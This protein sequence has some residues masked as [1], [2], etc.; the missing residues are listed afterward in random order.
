VKLTVKNWTE[1][2]HYK[3]RCPPW[4]KLHRKILDDRSFQRLPDASR[5]LAPCIWLL[6]SEST[7]GIFDGSVEEVAFRVRQ[8]EQWVEKAIKP[9]ITNGFLIVVQDVSASLADCHQDAC[10]ETETET[11]ARKKPAL[12]DWL[13]VDSWKGWIQSRKTK[14]TARAL[15]LAI[16]KL[17]GFRAK[18]IDPA[19]VLDASTLGG[20]TGLYE[21]KD[22][23][24]P[25]LMG[26]LSL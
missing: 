5:A 7:D 11:E 12:P 2:Q 18:G 20:W 1:F 4:I 22:A 3:D 21:P 10:L 23:P 16:A 8:S 13:P 9:L 19:S 14:P 17:D 24:K 25:V 15:S 26:G 6:A